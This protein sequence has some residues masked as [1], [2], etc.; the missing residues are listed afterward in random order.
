MCRLPA[1]TIVPVIVDGPSSY[2]LILFL[3]A[4]VSNVPSWLQLPQLT[5]T[6]DFPSWP[7][8]V[9]QLGDE[10]AAVT[11]LATEPYAIA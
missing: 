11:A 3:R 8:C 4:A 7:A 10:Q 5:Q 2:A 9:H 1:N 6:E